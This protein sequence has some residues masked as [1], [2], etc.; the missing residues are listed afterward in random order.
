MS[1]TRPHIAF[2]AALYTLLGAF[3]SDGL[4]AL[5][6]PAVALAA[7]VVALVVS[8]G[9]VINDYADYDLDRATKPTRPL[10]A[11]L[12]TPAAALQIASAV[13][14]VA[15]TVATALPPTLMLVACGNVALTT[16]YAFLLKRTVLLGNVAMAL[17]N[18]S[19]VLFG[20][21]AAAEI[22]VIVWVV[23][24]VS[25]LYTLAQEVLYTVDDR[26]GDAA[27]GILTTAVF[28]GVGPSLLL[29]RALL[30]LTLLATVMPVLEGIAPLWYLVALIVCTIAPML[31]LVFPLL[32]AR[33]AEAI[34]RACRWVRLIR[35]TSLLP[36]VL[37]CAL[38]P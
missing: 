37:L 23:A 11:G 12:F 22:T 5:G 18:S 15:L 19:V 1:L 29:V 8:F 30:L 21:L 14:L 35:L 27:A 24:T 34:P 3:L 7:L 10:P 6:R 20:A 36:F 2:Q 25:L 26:Q 32:H 4:V 33:S 16:A 31:G 9:F 28:F 38:Q 17:L 13:A